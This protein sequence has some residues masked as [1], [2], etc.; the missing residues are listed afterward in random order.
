M[1]FVKSTSIKIGLAMSFAEEKQNDMLYQ[2][3][4]YDTF[5]IS[6][7]PSISELDRACERYG[8]ETNL[9]TGCYM[10]RSI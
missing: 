1:R 10:C 5:L 2:D 6:I 9:N 3:G 7:D 4:F 8:V